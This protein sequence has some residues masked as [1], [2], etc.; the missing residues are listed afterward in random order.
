MTESKNGAKRT[1]T[2]PVKRNLALRQALEVAQ[3]SQPAV[4]PTSKSEGCWS[5]G[6]LRVWKPATQP[7]W[8]SALRWLC[9]A[10]PKQAHLWLNTV[11]V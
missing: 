11:A 1:Q 7:I 8:K 3:V 4:S 9:P 10:A 2:K 5:A 6:G